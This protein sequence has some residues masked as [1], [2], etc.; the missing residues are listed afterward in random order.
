MGEQFVGAATPEMVRYVLR[1]IDRVNY[2]EESK[3]NPPFPRL[4][5]LSRGGR[6]TKRGIFNPV[7]MEDMPDAWMQPQHIVGRFFG[8]DHSMSRG[9]FLRSGSGTKLW[10]MPVPSRHGTIS[11]YLLQ[12]EL[13][14][15]DSEYK[16]R[17]YREGV[18]WQPGSLPAPVSGATER[19][20]HKQLI[21]TYDAC[22]RLS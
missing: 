13:R 12:L 20:R 5:Y 3:D 1:K 2:A 4:V 19:E 11:G 14:R 7:T 10:I 15:A 22:M 21:E 18:R 16:V 9:F 6:D 17:L 8:F